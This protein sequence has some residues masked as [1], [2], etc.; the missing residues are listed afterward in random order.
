METVTGVMGPQAQD[1]WSPQKLQEAGWTLPQSLRG[2]LEPY[3]PRARS[4][5][6][7]TVYTYS[8]NT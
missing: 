2:K 7:H 4:S 8:S 3:F 1:A 5:A 6:Y